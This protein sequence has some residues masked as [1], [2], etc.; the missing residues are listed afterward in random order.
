MT[1][2]STNYWMKTVFRSKHYIQAL[3]I[4]TCLLFGTFPVHADNMEELARTLISIR[5]EVEDL[6][7]QLESAKQN[8]KLR[9]ESLNTQQTDLSVENQRQTVALEKL[10]QAIAKHKQDTEVF[11]QS[12]TS[13][14]PILSTTI[15][16]LENTVRQGLPF[17]IEERLSV[18]ADLKQQL[19][20]NALDGK[21]AANRL[22][23]FIEDEILL[24][25]ENGIYSQTIELAGEKRLVEVAKIG[26]AMLY[27][28]SE[29]QRSGKAV[30]Q[31]D[32]WKFVEFTQQGDKEKIALLFDALKKQIR[33]GYF[34]LP[35]PEAS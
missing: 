9:L 15:G 8:H 16:N 11:K 5:G 18:L 26:S 20:A 21:K 29:D 34:E 25:R 1:F 19:Q 22:W 4:S 6:Q 31:G 23:A 7:S 3:N 28:R 35:N 10:Q 32:A 17:K 27:F 12:E 2:T 13:L 14:V 33:Q 24:S 30:K